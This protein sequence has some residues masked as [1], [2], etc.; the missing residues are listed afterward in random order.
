MRLVRDRRALFFVIA[1][2][3]CLALVPV[4][5]PNL[6]WVPEVTAGAYVVLALLSF[7]DAVS[8]RRSR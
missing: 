1:A 6:R 7:L 5:E 8:R 3:L 2:V 4:A